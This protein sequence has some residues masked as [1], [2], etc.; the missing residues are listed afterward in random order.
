MC[1]TR[2]EG[3][4][5]TVRR[6]PNI[7]SGC[8]RDCLKGGDH[9]QCSTPEKHAT[10][11]GGLPPLQTEHTHPKPRGNT[12]LNTVWKGGS[13]CAAIHTPKT[14]AW[15]A[16]AAPFVYQAAPSQRT[17]APVTLQASNTAPYHQARGHCTALACVLLPCCCTPAPASC[18]SSARAVLFQP[19]LSPEQP[20]SMI[21]RVGFTLHILL[22][23]SHCASSSPPALLLLHCPTD[24]LTAQAW[25]RNSYNT[26]T[27]NNNSKEPHNDAITRPT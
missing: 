11:T 23:S 2:T 24:H 10:Q 16:G 15:R 22:R 3:T 25:V 12:L 21:Q 17:Q 27:E 1:R 26:N 14:G 8:R 9:R 18:H 20:V 5:S 4:H 13:S 19:L 6:E 7:T